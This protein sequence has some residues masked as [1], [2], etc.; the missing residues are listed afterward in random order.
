METLQAIGGFILLCSQFVHIRMIKYCIV[1]TIYGRTTAERGP[2]ATSGRLCTSSRAAEYSGSCS[3]FCGA[4]TGIDRFPM[5]VRRP[6]HE[7]QAT[8]SGAKRTGRVP[9]C[10]MTA[11]RT[12]RPR[13]AAGEYAPRRLPAFRTVFC[14]TRP[15][16]SPARNDPKRKDGGSPP[17]E[18]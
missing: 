10:A 12:G 18:I 16:G 17:T 3:R 11:R 7:R 6:P 5:P 9:R 15:G 14:K 4:D 2:E 13:P 8:L 1:I